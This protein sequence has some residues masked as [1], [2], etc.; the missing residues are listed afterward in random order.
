MWWW[1]ITERV[2]NEGQFDGKTLRGWEG[3]VDVA[4]P[5]FSVSYRA[6]QWWYLD[7]GFLADQAT[8]HGAEVRITVWRADGSVKNQ[9]IFSTVALQIRDHDDPPWLWGVTDQTAPT[10]PAWMKDDAKW[11]AA[12]DAQK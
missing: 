8:V 11:Q 7:S 5:W 1:V 3:S 9:V 10:I 2:Y 6:A 4:S 12:L